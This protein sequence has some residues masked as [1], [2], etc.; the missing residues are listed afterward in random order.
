MGEVWKDIIGY[1]R[2][3]LVSSKGRVK[4]LSRL[5][6]GPYGSL[7]KVKERVIRFCT[8]ARQ[9]YPL[10]TL[11]KSGVQVKVYVHR[12]VL[13]AFVGPCPEGMEC[14]H[15][16]GN[17]GNCRLENLTWGTRRQQYQD[18]VRHGTVKNPPIIYGEK[19]HASKMSIV[20]AEEARLL[21]ATGGWT[22]RK[23]AAKYGISQPVM[24]AILRWERYT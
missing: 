19:H 1:E 16:D 8:S 13:E 21:Y 9:K 10:I 18:R 2:A 4:S 11:T 17:P 22:Q 12:L 14:R 7:V 6:V 20:K 15:L 24:G 5:R 3:Y 23:L